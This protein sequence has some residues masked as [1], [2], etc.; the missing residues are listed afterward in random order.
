MPDNGLTF[1]QATIAATI[2]GFVGFL[3]AGIALT[4]IG[5]LLVGAQ[6]TNGG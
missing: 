5:P 6:P 4:F 3:L 1:G 2:G